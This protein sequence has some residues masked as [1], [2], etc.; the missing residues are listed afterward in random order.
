MARPELRRAGTREEEVGSMAIR[1]NVS[2]T[3]RAL[4]LIVSGSLLARALARASSRSSWGLG[5]IAGALAYRSLRGQCPLYRALGVRTAAE[6]G[7]QGR[8]ATAP[9]ALLVEKSTT[10]KRPRD[11]VY[12]FCRTLDNLPLFMT[13]VQA[14]KTAP[15][16]TSHWTVQ[17]PA[18]ITLEWDAEVTADTPGEVIAWS[19]RADSD[20]RHEG[21]VRFAPAPGAR[22]TEIRVQLRYECMGGKLAALVATLMGEEPS[23]QVES[24]LRRLK[25][26]LE[27]GEVATG[28]RR[29]GM[30]D[31]APRAWR[32]T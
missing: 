17:G 13:H 6:S 20:V 25:Q 12:R 29:R 5:L 11:E 16:G 24:D 8:V 21:T 4:T 1:V 23:Q 15:D 14:V 30:N 26:I 2:D 31:M 7:E 10:I 22:G 27:A 32:W 28:T 3:E 18:G 19:T 9:S